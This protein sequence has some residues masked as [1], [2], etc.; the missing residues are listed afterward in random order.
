MAAC[1]RDGQ[2]VES[3]VGPG[4]VASPYPLSCE[5][6]VD[7][8]HVGGSTDVVGFFFRAAQLYGWRS[9][10][11]V[12][13]SR[14]PCGIWTSSEA[15]TVREDNLMLSPRGGEACVAWCARD[16]RVFGVDQFLFEKR[17]LKSVFH[18]C[19]PL[20]GC[21]VTVCSP[22][23][24]AIP[25]LGGWVEVCACGGRRGWVVKE[26]GGVVVCSV[27]RVVWWRV[28]CGGGAWWCVVCCGVVLLG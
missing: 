22:V 9:A 18:G 27:W 11:L 5:R 3:A 13:S 26:S 21:E 4:L 17:R 8:R 28:V 24:Q 25:C 12:S 6:L 14:S 10:V 19:H 2:A 16:R 1:V 23:S 20:Q 15:S 7:G